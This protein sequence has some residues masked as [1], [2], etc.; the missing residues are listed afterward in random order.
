MFGA[1]PVMAKLVAAGIAADGFWFP[2]HGCSPTLR[3]WET[4]STPS[5]VHIMSPIDAAFIFMHFLKA[6]WGIKKALKASAPELGKLFVFFQCL[7]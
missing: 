7:K 3:S 4:R 1:I 6:F 2:G 5:L